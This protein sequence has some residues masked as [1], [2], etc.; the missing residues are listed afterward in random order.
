M[1]PPATCHSERSEESSRHST[2]L[3]YAGRRCCRRESLHF[4]Q[5]D[6]KHCMCGTRCQ[7]AGCATPPALDSIQRPDERRLL[8]EEAIE[9]HSPGAGLCP[10]VGE[11]GVEFV[12][13]PVAKEELEK[14]QLRKRTGRLPVMRFG[15]RLD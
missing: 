12:E 6:K 8:R 1:L 10:A 4:V 14:R 15:P 2:G 3:R 5:G 7:L 9:E 13:R 11:G